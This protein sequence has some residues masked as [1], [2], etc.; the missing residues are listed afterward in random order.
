MLVRT[1]DKMTDEKKQVL[2]K[3]AED[4]LRGLDLENE[5]ASLN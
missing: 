1:Y 5:Q 3:D 4:F 2:Q